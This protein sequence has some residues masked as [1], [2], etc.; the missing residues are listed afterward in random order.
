[1]LYSA[2]IIIGIIYLIIQVYLGWIIGKASVKVEKKVKEIEV[3]DYDPAYIN[4]DW[5]EMFISILNA[6]AVLSDEKVE[7][8]HSKHYK[9]FKLCYKGKEYIL[10]N[11]NAVFDKLNQFMAELEKERK[12]YA[13][14]F[15]SR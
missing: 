3:N 4:K 2:Q 11:E 13:K 12:S 14:R 1:M 10:N 5:F 8:Y 9:K 15:K 6:Q 7:L